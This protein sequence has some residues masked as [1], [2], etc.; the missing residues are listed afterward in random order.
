MRK[1]YVQLISVTVIVA[2]VVAVSQPV[3][4]QSFSDSAVHVQGSSNTG[5]A[6]DATM[7]IFAERAEK[8]GIKLEVLPES[9]M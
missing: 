7:Q 5:N 2:V 3:I 1:I 6:T 4:I 8:S 9:D